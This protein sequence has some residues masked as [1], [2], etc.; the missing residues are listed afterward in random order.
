M[1]VNERLLWTL[2]ILALM[3]ILFIPNERAGAIV[4]MLF[5]LA[6][7]VHVTKKSAEYQQERKADE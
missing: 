2:F 5:M 3:S 1:K 7:W 6:G 4:G